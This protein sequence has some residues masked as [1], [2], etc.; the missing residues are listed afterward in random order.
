M[1]P[2]GQSHRLPG[3]FGPKLVAMM[4]AFHS[5]SSVWEGRR[6]ADP[7][8]RT[9]ECRPSPQNRRRMLAAIAGEFKDKFRRH[10][11]WTGDSNFRSTWMRAIGARTAMSASRI[12]AHALARTKLSALLTGSRGLEPNAV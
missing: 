5:N 11:A 4:R 7:K 12:C 2:A 8:R 3:V 6:A 10:F 1:D 9:A